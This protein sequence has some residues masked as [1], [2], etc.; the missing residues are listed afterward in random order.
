M[1]SHSPFFFL[2]F[3]P[4]FCFVSKER[5]RH[6]PY[7]LFWVT[8]TLNTLQSTLAH[9]QWN[10]L[11]VKYHVK[12][13]MVK[14]KQT[15]TFPLTLKKLQ[16]KMPKSNNNINNVRMF[17]SLSVLSINYRKW[18]KRGAKKKRGMKADEKLEIIFY[19]LSGFIY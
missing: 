10:P 13:E 2:C 7:C 5:I 11:I 6:E 1:H 8:V 9:P 3:S 4:L 14:R 16:R 19:H 12:F 15:S 17:F 18:C